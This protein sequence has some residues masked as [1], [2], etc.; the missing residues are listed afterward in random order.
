[1][2]I[3]FTFFLL[4]TFSIPSLAISLALSCTIEERI[5]KSSFVT[6]GV[7]PLPC[8]TEEA[9]RIAYK[10]GQTP[11][12]ILRADMLIKLAKASREKQ[13][14][15]YHIL[16]KLSA[17]SILYFA[18]SPK[19]IV[20]RSEDFE[21]INVSI[22]LLGDHANTYFKNLFPE[23]HVP[24]STHL[25]ALDSYHSL[26]YLKKG[27]IQVMLL[28]VSEKYF[29][30]YQKRMQPYPLALSKVL[31]AD[32]NLKCTED[33]CS[34]AYYLI[35]KDKI[36][37]KVMHNIYLNAET[38]FDKNKISLDQDLGAYYI[39]T[40]LTKPQAITVHKQVIIDEDPKPNYT[41]RFGRAPWMDLAISEAIEG[42]GSSEYVVPMLALSYKYIR[43]AKGKGGITTAP[44][45]SVEGSWCAAY[46]CWTLDKSGYT[47]HQKGR[48]ASQSFRYFNNKLYR[49]I[50]QPIFGAITLFT[51]VRN[52]AH[53]HVGYLFGKTAS[54]KYIVL[55]GNQSNKLKFSAYP[56]YFAGNKLK[57]F[58]V[59][60][61]YK[62]EEKDTLT[63]KDIYSSAEVLNLKYGIKGGGKGYGTR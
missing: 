10:K 63:S 47:I 11:L 30:K 41:K 51:K 1:M 32:S 14:P 46:I 6:K 49:K 28:F 8:M 58:Y 23:H 13:M 22:G 4:L 56:R 16:G 61:D 57:G 39:D 34:A 26:G 3:V 53:G 27:K 62:I 24:Y 5:S 43:F 9:V 12:A 42:K 60:I 25:Y 55:G 36:G 40:H 38:I 7:N 33:Y 52:P 29:E 31:A 15:A 20:S 18:T 37:P 17:K 59:P 54:G 48:M 2:K 50:K 21:D 44:N 45:D 19:H 35:A